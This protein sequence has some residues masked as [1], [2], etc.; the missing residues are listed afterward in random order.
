MPDDQEVKYKLAQRQ[1]TDAEVKL[2][3]YAVLEAKILILLHNQGDQDVDVLAT[4]LG[5]KD[6][7]EAKRPLRLALGSL[8]KKGL[9][10]PSSCVIPGIAVIDDI[11]PS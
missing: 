5:F 1:L 6:D 2:R 11:R 9:I 4:K 8:V 7:I 3:S 10:R